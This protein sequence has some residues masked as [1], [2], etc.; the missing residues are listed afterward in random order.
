MYIYIYI[1]THIQGSGTQSTNSTLYTN[2]APHAR[3]K[4]RSDPSKSTEDL[5][6]ASD[7]GSV[8]TY[9]HALRP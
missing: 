7:L 3:R 6:A 5:S 9:Q 2:Q 1:Y 8:P 4:R